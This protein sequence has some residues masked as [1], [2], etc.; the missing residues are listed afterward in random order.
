MY[1]RVTLLADDTRNYI[2]HGL[3]STLII[4]NNPTPTSKHQHC[5]TLRSIDLFNDVGVPIMHNTEMLAKHTDYSARTPRVCVPRSDGPVCASTEEV[6]LSRT[7]KHPHNSVDRR[8]THSTEV[9]RLNLFLGLSQLSAW[10][11]YSGCTCRWR[12]AVCGAAV[13]IA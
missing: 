1:C 13:C 9:R 6:Y 11:V 7:T 10:A 2:K 3:G 4:T 8:E 5:N 12:A